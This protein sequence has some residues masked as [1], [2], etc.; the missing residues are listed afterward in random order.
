MDR[1]PQRGGEGRA[2]MRYRIA[3]SPRRDCGEPIESSQDEQELRA[4]ELKEIG[5][6]LAAHRV[7]WC[8][9]DQFP[10]TRRSCKRRDCPRCSREK[11]V[12]VARKNKRILE[13]MGEY[14]V[15]LLDYGY[16]PFGKLWKA[17]DEM[18]AALSRIRERC[19]RL[20]IS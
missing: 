10:Y 1:G 6:H 12:L 13:R 14:E 8:G 9:A 17:L 20:G 3:S 16:C 15:L 19:T 5:D 7:R 18:S 11:A 4:L 2:T